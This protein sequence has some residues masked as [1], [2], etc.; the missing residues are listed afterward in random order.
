[1]GATSKPFP[2]LQSGFPVKNEKVQ[3]SGNSL[4]MLGILPLDVA[5]A[6]FR[7]PRRHS[8]VFPG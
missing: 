5:L 7:G 2:K 6:G 8:Q 1:M 3:W 4:G